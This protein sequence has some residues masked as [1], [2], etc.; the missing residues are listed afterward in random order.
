MREKKKL[1]AVNLKTIVA[2]GF[3]ATV[4]ML[5]FMFVKIP[6]P[7]LGT[8]LQLAYGIAGFFGALF[9]PVAGFLIAFIGHTLFFFLQYGSPWWSWVIASGVAGFVYGIAFKFVNADPFKVK[10]AMIF[11]VIQIIG[12]AIAWILIAPVLDIWMYGEIVSLAFV[13]GAIAAIMNSISC[14]VIG[15]LLLILYSAIHRNKLSLNEAE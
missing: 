12:N 2:T 9:G 14:G 7:L 11:N 3:G 6:S 10:D 4:F 8:Q 15:T 13:Q 1:F 5:L